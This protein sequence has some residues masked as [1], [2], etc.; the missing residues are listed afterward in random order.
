MSINQRVSFAAVCLFLLMSLSVFSQNARIDS[1]K[2]IVKTAEKDTAMVTTLNVLSSSFIGIGEASESLIY[3]AKANKLATE[4]DFTKGKAYGLK[5]L[6]IGYFYQGNFEEADKYLNESLENFEILRDSTGI[7]NILN[8]L[9]TVHFSQGRDAPAL[10]YFLRSLRIAEKLKNPLR[11]ASALVNV[12]GVY[13]EEVRDFDIAMKYY[14]QAIPYLKIINTPGISKNVLLGIGTLYLKKGV[15][16]DEK[17]NFENVNQ[18]Y[19]NALVKFEEALPITENTFFYS[20][21]LTFIGQTHFKLGNIDKA[22]EYLDRA[23]SVAV[24]N[25]QKFELAKALVAKGN[26][27]QK[28]NPQK[29]I[30]IYYEA[31]LMAKNMNLT[32]ELK[33]IYEG[34]FKAYVNKGDFKKGYEYQV[35]YVAQKDSLFNL[36]TD[37]KIRGL[38]F[39]FDLDKKQDEIELLEKKAE[40]TDLQQKR[41][42]SALI[43]LILTSAIVLLLAIGLYR[44]Y[45]FIRKTN[46][47]INEE[48]D[49]AEELL[50]NILPYET[51]KELQLNG[52]VKAKRSESVTVMFTDFI[53][54][55]EYSENLTPE[56][57]VKSVDFFFSKFDT[58][59]EK[60][61]LEKIKTIGD[62]Y[63]CAGGLPFPLED[64]AIK[65]VNA[66]FEI[67][68]VMEEAKL[69]EDD[70][71]SHFDIRIGINTGPIVA[72]V[73]GIK[74]FAYDIWGDT[75]NIASRMESASKSGRINISSNTHELIKDHF[76]C[77]YR[78]EFEVK[79]RGIL[80]MYFVNGKKDVNETKVLEDSSLKT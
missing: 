15:D 69:V 41:Q 54:F 37:D 58:I 74:K 31:E 13:S 63:M 53:G 10:E 28:V 60:Y 78:G 64:H 55:T 32:Y 33:D 49:R 35:K 12:A 70:D 5:W 23:N 16:E 47:V 52:K 59:M 39:N 67:L 80:K 30:N 22:I 18:N 21:N 72:G 65:V 75:V 1:L 57:L 9:G 36:E 61:G 8:N 46:E 24:E 42:K 20:E 34:I 68:E 66:A 17:G 79:N 77:K 7:A 71:I 6:G 26:L 45:R 38:Q 56:A 2:N 11:I 44:R 40:I 3:S 25:D 76:T 73:V 27:Y 48:K 14:N 4:L 19:E 43:T 51:A 62:A 50:L 29:A